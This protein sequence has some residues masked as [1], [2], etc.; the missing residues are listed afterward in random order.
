VSR[1]VVVAVTRRLIVRRLD[2]GD[3]AAMLEVY[4]DRDAMRWV[5]DGDVLSA[6]ECDRW[7]EVTA[8]N[9]RRR[10]YGMFAMTDRTAPDEVVGF[11]GL[12]HP[13]SQPEPEVKYALRRASW[14]QGLATEAVQAVIRYGFADHGLTRIIATTAPENAASH[15]VLRKAGFRDARPRANEDGTWDRVFVIDCTGAG[16]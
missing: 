16:R 15:R 5:G 14:G 1:E 11:I 7:L 4:G 2:P 9:Y 13:G 12:V 6:A 10:G 3:R 8:E